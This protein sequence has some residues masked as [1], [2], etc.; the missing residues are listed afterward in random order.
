MKY[1]SP[2][3]GCLFVPNKMNIAIRKLSNENRANKSSLNLPL[4]LFDIFQCNNEKTKVGTDK[5]KQYKLNFES[6]AKYNG[7]T[8]NKYR[9]AKSLL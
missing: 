3:E 9:T 7:K 6:A 2:S 1:P 5:I 8:N 4:R